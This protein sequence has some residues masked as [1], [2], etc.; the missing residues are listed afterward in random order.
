MQEQKNTSWNQTDE[1][2]TAAE[3]S[4]TCSWLT[5]QSPSFSKWPQGPQSFNLTEDE[6]CLELLLGA[7]LVNQYTQL[8]AKQPLFDRLQVKYWLFKSETQNTDPA[9]LLAKMMKQ[10]CKLV[11]HESEKNKCVVDMICTP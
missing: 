1:N 5:F 7:R 9:W 2:V 8:H 10:Q 6:P 11:S 3:C 4:T